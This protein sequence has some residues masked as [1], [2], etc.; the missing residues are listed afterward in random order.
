M[1]PEGQ[2]EADLQL[3]EEFRKRFAMHFVHLEESFPTKQYPISQLLSQSL[4]IF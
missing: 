4:Q 3:F 2:D 1:N